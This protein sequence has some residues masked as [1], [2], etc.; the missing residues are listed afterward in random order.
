[1][2]VNDPIADM[3]TRVRNAVMAGQLVVAMPSS[4]IKAALY[5]L[6]RSTISFSGASSPSMEYIDS[7]A[8]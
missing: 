3:L 6:H 1:M 4:T 5:L 2:S 8:T 7:I